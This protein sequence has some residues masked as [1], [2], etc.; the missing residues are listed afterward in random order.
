M[1]KPGCI[2]GKRGKFALA[3]A[4]SLEVLET[5]RVTKTEDVHTGIGRK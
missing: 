4:A 2:K 3:G 5:D 1:T